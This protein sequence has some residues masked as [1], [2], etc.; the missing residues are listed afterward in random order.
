M[1]NGPDDGERKRR[2]VALRA[3]LVCL[4]LAVLAWLGFNAFQWHVT[5]QDGVAS[6]EPGHIVGR[7]V[8]SGIVVVC[9][10]L[11]PWLCI[12]FAV[13]F[14][15]R[16]ALRSVLWAVLTVT[17]VVLLLGTGLLLSLLTLMSFQS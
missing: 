2:R 3:L 13:H 7:A 17:V 5:V 4:G 9:F 6:W 1:A 16:T 15:A 12:V 8:M 10:A 14:P 11:V